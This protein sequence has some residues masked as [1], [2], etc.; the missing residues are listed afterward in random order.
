[1]LISAEKSQVLIVDVQENLA[2]V[3]EEPRK[4]IHGCAILVL[5]ASRL[6]LPITASEQ[7]PKGLGPIMVDLRELV[8]QGSV[9]EKTAF[10]CAAEPALMEKIQGN[11]RSQVIIAGVEAHVC[12]LQSAFGLKEAGFSV[13]VV[14]DACSSRRLASERAAYERM[15]AAGVHLVTLEMVLFE[16]LG[17]KAHPAF[18]DIQRLIK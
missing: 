16:W 17:G 3:M 11:G 13:F 10:S 6:G 8:P 2:P 12:V 1:M 18:R 14:T 7:Y 9:I 4:V 15:A 5:A